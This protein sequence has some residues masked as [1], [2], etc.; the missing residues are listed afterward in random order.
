MRIPSLPTIH[1]S[2]QWQL[3]SCFGNKS[4][5]YLVIKSLQWLFT[6]HKRSQTPSHD[7]LGAAVSCSLLSPTSSRS[8][9]HLVQRALAILPPSGPLHMHLQCSSLSSSLL[10]LPLLAA[11]HFSQNSLNVTSLGKVLITNS[12]HFLLY[13]TEHSFRVGTPFLLLMFFPNISLNTA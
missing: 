1:S 11:F 4:N 9:V 6:A 13:A 5:C 7:L 8:T 3:Y 10:F 2:A 12:V